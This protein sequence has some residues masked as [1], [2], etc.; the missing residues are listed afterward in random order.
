M[1]TH[2]CGVA[3]QVTPQTTDQASGL[4]CSNP[5]FPELL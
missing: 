3:N 2:Y 4:F 1:L 5:T